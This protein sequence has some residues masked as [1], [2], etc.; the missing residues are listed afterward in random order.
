MNWPSVLGLQFENLVLQNRSAIYEHLGLSPY[1]IECDGP[2]TQYK[3]VE[4]HGCQIDY[5]IQDRFSTLY[6]CEIKFSQNPIGVSVVDTFEQKIKHLKVP[7]HV[8]FRPILIHAN[9]I[10]Q[11]LS[12]RSYFYKI[13]DFSQML[14]SKMQ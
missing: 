13:I 9:E 6:V 14:R 11:D 3:T 7:K 1:D 2:Y 12:S 4:Q 10:T 8:S 5:L